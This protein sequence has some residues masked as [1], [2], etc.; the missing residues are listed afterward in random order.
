[1]AWVH[2]KWHFSSLRDFHDYCND[3]N[4]ANN[5]IKIDV[6]GVDKVPLELKKK[7]TYITK[8]FDKIS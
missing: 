3:K 8:A 5:E 6:Q 7:P 2:A 1:M 4:L